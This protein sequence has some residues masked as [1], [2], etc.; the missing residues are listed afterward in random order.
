MTGGTLPAQ[1]WHEIMVYA[2]QGLE[3]SRPTASRPGAGAGADRR[4]HSGENGR[5]HRRGAAQVGLSPH[6]TQIIL[7]IGDFARP[8][9]WRP[10]RDAGSTR[11]A[12]RS[13][14]RR[15][16]HAG[17]REPAPEGCSLAV[18]GAGSSA[19]HGA[20]WRSAPQLKRPALILA[21]CG[22]ATQ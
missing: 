20:G 14:T 3:P 4:R 5:R 18:S 16:P 15:R 7:E 12:G 22:R 2:H 9:G 1:T 10:D 19:S 17:S 8:L 21:S 6:S 13:S 11:D